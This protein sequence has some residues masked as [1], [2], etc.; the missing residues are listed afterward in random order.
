M[1]LPWR[2]GGR[3]GRRRDLFHAPLF[4]GVFYY[5]PGVLEYGS[6]EVLEKAKARI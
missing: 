2:R 1:V 4:R 3:V 6:I 5:A